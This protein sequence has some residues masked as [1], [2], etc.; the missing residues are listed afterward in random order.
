[1]HRDT[2]SCLTLSVQLTDPGSNEAG[3]RFT[4]TD[5]DRRTSVHELAR[6]DAILFCSDMVHNVTT[7]QHGTR[8]SLVL[9]LWGSEEN[10]RDRDH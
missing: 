2:G 3:G 6:G 8:N 1:M 4:T 7:L 5:A 10:V 9:E